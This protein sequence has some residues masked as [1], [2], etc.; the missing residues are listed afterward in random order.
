MEKYLSILN[1]F[2][3][4]D[5]ITQGLNFIVANLYQVVACIIT[6]M[7]FMMVFLYV[8]KVYQY[9]H[10]RDLAKDATE[11]ANQAELMRQ[12]T[13]KSWENADADY[14]KT[15]LDFVSEL[16]LAKAEYETELETR[17]HIWEGQ[18]KQLRD[19]IKG[20]KDENREKAINQAIGFSKGLIMTPEDLIEMA[21]KIYKFYNGKP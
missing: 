15:T 11:R 14:K 13:E 21:Q 7:L 5:L 18:M 6:A 10:A 20:L 4:G 9:R 8:D 17:G 3:L 19:E 1:S 16:K 2:N 12:V